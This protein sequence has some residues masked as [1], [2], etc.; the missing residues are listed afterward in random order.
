M[1]KINSIVWEN[2][3]VEQ[4]W[5]NQIK[6]QVMNIANSLDAKFAQ[7]NT[8]SNVLQRKSVQTVQEQDV[9]PLK[10]LQEN[11]NPSNAT[12]LIQNQFVKLKDPP[13]ASQRKLEL[14]NPII[15]VVDQN[16]AFMKTMEVEIQKFLVNGQV[17]KFVKI[18]LI[19]LA[20]MLKFLKIA[21][22]ENVAN[23]LELVQLQEKFTVILIVNLQR[24]AP[25][26][27]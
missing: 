10:K 1:L 26:I 5:Q 11:K 13:N 20:Q 4:N 21:S 14:E 25:K 22:R 6:N 7:K 12:G 8:Q 18:F 9:V 15:I 2:V 16:V 27:L 3:V 17:Q 24:F 23:S 19:P